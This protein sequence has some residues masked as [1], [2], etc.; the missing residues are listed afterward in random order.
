V[1]G[2]ASDSSHARPLLEAVGH[3]ASL[4]VGAEGPAEEEDVGLGPA[5]EER[6]TGVRSWTN[7]TVS[8]PHRDG[9]CKRLQK[10]SRRMTD[11]VM[12]KVRREKKR[13]R[14]SER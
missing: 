12:D 5:G 1:S 3:L 8:G 2:D 13:V 10:R 7:M 6:R 11:C 4:G 9:E 14:K